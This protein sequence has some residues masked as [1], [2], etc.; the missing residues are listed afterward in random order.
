MTRE[1]AIRIQRALNALAYP[2]TIDGIIGPESH[3]ALMDFQRSRGLAV[4]GDP[5]PQTTAALW[6]AVPPEMPPAPSSDA[7]QLAGER[8]VAE[9]QRLWSLDVYDPRV[10]DDTENGKRCKAI[11]S[12]IVRDAGWTWAVPYRGDGAVQWCGMFAAAC[13]RTAGID[14]Q[15]LATFWA[16]TLRMAT[17][18]RYRDWNETSAG[19]RP[20]SGGRM[21]MRGTDATFPDGTLPRAG[22]IVIVGDGTPAEG[23]HITLL[24]R[25]SPSVFHTVSGNGGGEGPVGKRREGI[26][27]ADYFATRGG[28]R[29][30]W[31]ARPGVG[32][33][34]A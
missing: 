23:D 3:R 1:E 15:W 31:V 33:L 34:L 29:V 16:S 5:N 7:L 18:F 4:N 19:D 8:A 10:A 14:P 30:L 20:A 11:I 27:K 26:S 24:E 12:D 22:D 17:W 32:D 13:W 9:A 21:I 2:V 28:Y 6:R 25:Y